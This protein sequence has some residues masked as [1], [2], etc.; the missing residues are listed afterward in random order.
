MYHARID[1]ADGDVLAEFLELI[2]RIES[3]PQTELPPL[4]GALHPEALANLLSTAGSDVSVTFRYTG[5][6]VTVTGDGGVVVD[7][8]HP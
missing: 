6:R 3:V 7:P 2:A 8:L 4:Y 1:T 5:S